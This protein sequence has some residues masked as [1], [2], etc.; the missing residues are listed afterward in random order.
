MIIGYAILGRGAQ[1]FEEALQITRALVEYGLSFQPPRFWVGSP[2]WNFWQ[3]AAHLENPDP[4]V[5]LP[6]VENVMIAIQEDPV[7]WVEHARRDRA[8]PLV[9]DTRTAFVA[10]DLE[11]H[12]VFTKRAEIPEV[13]QTYL[14]RAMLARDDEY[15]ELYI[16]DFAGVFEMGYHPIAIAGLKPMANYKNKA[17]QQA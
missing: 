16:R 15:I 17:I 6:L 13:I 5:I 8:V 9:N 3:G 11:A 2:I 4:D 12:Y 10:V 14:E 1:S 7:L